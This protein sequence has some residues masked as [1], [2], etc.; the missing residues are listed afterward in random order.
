MV[1][2]SR[3]KWL[4]LHPVPFDGEATHVPEIV[5]EIMDEVYRASHNKSRRLVA[6]G[7]RATLEH[8]IIDKVGD[9]GNFTDKLDKM[10]KD[11]YL[12]RRQRMDLDTILLR[13]ATRRSIGAGSQRTSRSALS[14]ILLRD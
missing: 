4:W 3:P 1:V 2:R 5:R 6:M 14:S 9:V 7:A 8:V 10:E 12:S 13:R 11:D